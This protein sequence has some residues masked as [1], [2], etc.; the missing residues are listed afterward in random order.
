MTTL[1]QEEFE[2]QQENYNEWIVVPEPGYAKLMKTFFPDFPA[3]KP[4][5]WEWVS[6][7]F[8]YPLSEDFLN[9]YEHMLYWQILSK[10]ACFKINGVFIDNGEIRCTFANCTNPAPDFEKH[11]NFDLVVITEVNLSMFNEDP[12]G[13]LAQIGT[14]VNFPDRDLFTVKLEDMTTAEKRPMHWFQKT[15][16]QRAYE[17]LENELARNYPEIS[18]TRRL[19]NHAQAVLATRVQSFAHAVQPRSQKKRKNRRNR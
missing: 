14:E 3:Q 1:L 5:F 13:F 10:Y 15:I 12:R 11:V 19:H 16:I 4:D 2:F 6:Y 9:S 7:T 8:A 18:S 17:V